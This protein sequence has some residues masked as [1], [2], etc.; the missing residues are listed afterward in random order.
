MFPDRDSL[1]QPLDDL[2]ASLERGLTMA[3]CHPDEQRSLSYRDQSDP[4]MNNHR[5]KP[6]PV[7]GLI[8]NQRQLPLRHR[9][10]GFIFN[11]LDHPL[12]LDGSDYPEKVD[13]RTFGPRKVEDTRIQRLFSYSDLTK[14]H[15]QPRWMFRYFETGTVN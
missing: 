3:R 1:F 4:M 8:G 13:H 9:L 2:A 5:N 15:C 6:V 12:I 7:F 11:G 14:L 10:K